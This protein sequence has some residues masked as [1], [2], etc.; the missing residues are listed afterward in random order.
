MRLYRAL[1]QKGWVESVYS[2]V[3]F[4]L[5]RGKIRSRF[6]PRDVSGTVVPCLLPR[7]LVSY[8]YMYVNIVDVV[9]VSV[10]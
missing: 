6:T 2:I 9:F 4:A 8:I 1:K 5:I 7:F 3:G 10:I